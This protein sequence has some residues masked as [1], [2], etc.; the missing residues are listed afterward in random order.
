MSANSELLLN[1]NKKA[2]S[3][4]WLRAVFLSVKLHLLFRQQDRD[5]T[6][7]DAG[8]E[9]AEMFGKQPFLLILVTE[10]THL[11]PLGRD[12]FV[13]QWA[14]L[15]LKGWVTH[16]TSSNQT[17]PCRQECGQGLYPG[18][19]RTG[20]HQPQEAPTLASALH[21]VMKKE[22]GKGK[23]HSHPPHSQ[24]TASSV[25]YLNEMGWVLAALVFE[26]FN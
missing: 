11:A 7:V 6:A 3:P 10:N 14:W 16:I 2:F 13:R 1:A 22:A 25:C 20:T 23:P 15:P 17:A 18:I 8:R 12:H 4:S 21:P 5:W 24:W 19:S 9:K 26:S